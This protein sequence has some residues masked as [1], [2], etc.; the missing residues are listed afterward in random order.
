MQTLELNKTLRTDLQ[1]QNV[2]NIAKS[3]ILV[4]TVL[5]VKKTM[6]KM[7]G[8]QSLFS[9]S[10]SNH[11][12]LTK[13]KVFLCVLGVYCCLFPQ[14]CKLRYLFPLLNVPYSGTGVSKCFEVGGRLWKSRRLLESRF[15]QPL[16]SRGVWAPPENFE[17]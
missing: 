9:S 14:N 3:V 8:S 17:I 12:K 6:I 7:R 5:Q 1:S 4:K 15:L 13:Q 16:D 2:S 10:I 11:L